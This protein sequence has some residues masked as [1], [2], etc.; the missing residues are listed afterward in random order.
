MDRGCLPLNASDRIRVLLMASSMRGGGSERQTLHLARSLD[1]ERF[2]PHLF[3]SEAAG[4]LFESV[5]EDVVIH[6]DATR[7]QPVGLHYPG[8]LLKRQSLAFEEL[9]R[10]RSIDVVY[11]RT[12]HMSMIAG[13]AALRSGVP[14][15][16]TIVSPP[17]RALPMVERRFIWLK[18]RR[19]AQIYLASSQ[20]IAVSQ[21]AADSAVRYYGLPPERIEVIRNPVPEIEVDRD[22]QIP[23]R[24]PGC[25]RLVCVGRMTA[26]KGHRELLQSLM[27]LEQRGADVNLHVHLLGD[28]PLRGEIESL[29]SRLER[30]QVF[31]HGYQ[32][33]PGDWIA[34]ADGLIL[35]SLFEGMP[36][37]VLEAMRLQTPVIA[38]RAG[39]TI[40]LERNKPTIFWANPG[41]PAS[42]AT[43]IEE[44]IANR[45]SHFDHAD[46]A[47]Q[48][49]NQ[50]HRVSK[51]TQQIESF[52]VDAV[53][54]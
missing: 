8:K 45:S 18:R 3:V 50:H 29:A 17:H 48:M 51:V 54:R 20:V 53:R 15:V 2:E 44:F 24:V 32:A 12:Y 27:M 5:P 46:A 38:T 31:V 36:N 22:F 9:I 34:A 4:E 35:P 37:V 33:R 39:G 42:L 11:D 47:L 21:Q 14:R 52:L 30:N 10:N 25:I 13:A 26:E 1:R 49:I 28:G 40:E 6:E 41:D 23:N 16:S 43:T 7:G 19:L